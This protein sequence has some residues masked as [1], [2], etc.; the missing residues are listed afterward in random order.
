RN[1]QKLNSFLHIIFSLGEDVSPE[2]KIPDN[3][4][5]GFLTSVTE[6]SRYISTGKARW[7]RALPLANADTLLQGL[8]NEK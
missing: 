2:A 1:N 3:M 4:H 5:L 8:T 7:T 6:I